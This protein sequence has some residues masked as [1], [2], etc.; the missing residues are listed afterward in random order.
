VNYCPSNLL[1]GSPPH[2]SPPC[3]CISTVYIQTMCGW[4]GGGG[5]DQILQ[6]FNTP[7]LTRLRT[8]KIDRPPQTKPWRGGGLRQIN[9][10]CKVSLQVIFLD[11][12][13]LH[14]FLLRLNHS[15]PRKS[16]TTS[17]SRPLMYTCSLFSKHITFCIPNL[18]YR[19]KI[20]QS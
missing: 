13:I 7:Y 11:D 16:C 15:L 3:L 5:G 20:Q 4:E 19:R 8:Y 14:C 10:C 2:P 6:E 12:D 1:S 9:T 17:H 18:T